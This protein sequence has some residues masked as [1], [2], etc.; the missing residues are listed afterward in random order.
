MMG[1][2]AGGAGGG[3]G[4]AGRQPFGFADIREVGTLDVQAAD[5]YFTENRD[6][7]IAELKEFLSIA[8]VSALPQHRGDI[9][10]AAEWLAAALRRAGVP[11]VRIMETG[12]HPVVFGQWPVADHLPTA[13]I[14]GHY[15]VQPVDPLD[16]WETPPFE[17]SLRDGRI[18]ARGASDDKGALYVA[19]KAVEA[20]SAL[21]GR[22]PINLKFVFEG[23]EEIGSPALPE[24]FRRHAGLLKADVAVCADGGQWDAD[25]PCLTVGSKGLAGIQ[26]DVEGANSDL[27]SGVHGGGVQNPIHALVAILA[28][29]RGGDGRIQVEGFYDRVRDL[30]PEERADIARVPF[31]EEEY[32]RS[33]G[34]DAL[35]GEAGYTT[36]ERQWAR[37]TLEVNG[38]WGGFQGEGVKTVLPSRA[39]AKI[40]CRLV[41]DQDPD[42]IIR[43]LEDH[44]RRHTPAGVRVTV[45]AFPG[46]AR[47]FL[48][49]REH[50]ALQ[51]AGRVL[52]EVYGREPLVVRTGG[53]IPV[54]ETFRSALGMWMV[55]FAF[56]DHDG[57]MHAPNEFMRLS[58]FDRGVR[59]T[60]RYLHALAGCR[61]EE[62]RAG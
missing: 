48:M 27:H 55:F 8:S 4:A 59:A 51:A 10:R 19:V 16:L 47:P 23:E 30:T 43:L 46:S 18:Y 53:T 13:L 62:L 35:F 32:K 9:V 50:P 7:H 52:A 54:A 5:R 20:L 1:V 28:S 29:M 42:E 37:P 31:D 15:D 57:N 38:I 26:I 41:P 21:D 2:A 25:T 56:G 40:T 36:L 24:F 39:H 33:L 22:P 11:D 49:P 34:V 45:R 58:S 17:P 12:G 6:R 44:V 61:P 60:Y 3:N 14:Y